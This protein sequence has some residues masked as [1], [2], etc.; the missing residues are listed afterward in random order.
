N[1]G[2]SVATNVSVSDPL[3][4]GVTSFSWSGN[5]KVSQPGALSDTIASLGVGASVTYTIVPAASAAATCTLT[6]LVSISAANHTTPHNHTA[7][8]IDTLSPQVDVRVTKTD[9]VTSR[10]PGP[11]PTRRSSDLNS[12]PSVA[13]NVSVS[14]PL[15]TGVTSFSWSGNGKVSQPGALSDTI[16]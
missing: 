8:D 13:T 3:P 2:P 15:P 4:T 16:A 5:G 9:N 14:D 10:D 12:G 11:F 1:S 7:T 6:N